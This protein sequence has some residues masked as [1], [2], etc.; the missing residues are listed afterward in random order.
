[1]TDASA[2]DDFLR[3]LRAEYVAEGNG[4][5][6]ALRADIA[7]L[8]NGTPGAAATLRG[9]LHQLAG[10]GGS[11]GFPAISAIAREAEQWLTGTPP[12]GAI[13]SRMEEAVARLE[14]E[15][16]KAKKAVGSER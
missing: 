9:R 1:M 16:G 11:Y 6:A 5:L 2:D 7:E 14:E 15:F 3:E 4:H 8:G 10:S 12:P 13:V